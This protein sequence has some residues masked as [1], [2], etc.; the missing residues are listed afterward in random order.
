MS[1]NGV[2]RKNKIIPVPNIKMELHMLMY[3]E[4]DGV[5]LSL[6]VKLIAM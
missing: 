6:I 4:N 2:S 1:I 5:N 3:L